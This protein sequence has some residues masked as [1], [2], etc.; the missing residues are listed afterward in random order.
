M[1][2]LFSIDTEIYSVGNAMKEMAFWLKWLFH[3]CLSIYKWRENWREAMHQLEET[4]SRENSQRSVFWSCLSD[5]NTSFWEK[6]YVLWLAMKMKRNDSWLSLHY[7]RE[8]ISTLER[9][10]KCLTCHKCYS[11]Y[12]WNVS[13]EI[14]CLW[15]MTFIEIIL[16]RQRLSVE[17]AS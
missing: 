13:E 7:M 14:L 9:N 5:R 10:V 1:K 12:D 3:L 6:I 8:A 15:W 17:K 2:W 11:F 16:R 4:V